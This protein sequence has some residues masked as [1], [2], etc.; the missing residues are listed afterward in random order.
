M[1]D[2]LI[3]FAHEFQFA[4]YQTRPNNE[5]DHFDYRWEVCHLI[6]IKLSLTKFD[7]F[8]IPYDK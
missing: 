5:F 2:E 7:I 6:I 1:P 4:H 8:N 3:D